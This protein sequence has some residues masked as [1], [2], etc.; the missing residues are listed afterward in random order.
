[1]YFVGMQTKDAK[2]TAITAG[3]FVVA[4]F[5]VSPQYLAKDTGGILLAWY[6]TYAQN[7]TD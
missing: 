2:K 6:I 3:V 5:T 7:I 4:V 1:M